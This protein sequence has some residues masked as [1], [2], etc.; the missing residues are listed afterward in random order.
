MKGVYSPKSN[1]RFATSNNENLQQIILITQQQLKNVVQ[2]SLK[3]KVLIRIH[4]IGKRVG[5]L[6]NK[7]INLKI[8]SDLKDEIQILLEK[9][10]KG[11]CEH[12][13]LQRLQ[14]ELQNKIIIIQKRLLKN[15][16]KYIKETQLKGLSNYEG[17][18]IVES[19]N[20]N[21]DKYDKISQEKNQYKKHNLK[22]KTLD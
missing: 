9:Q 22:S 19:K 2:A 3:Q 8:L 11:S 13:L 7:P 16:V 20:N 5:N 14:I 15:V 17:Y 4:E 10:N 21:K 1:G 12:I 18:N 6:M